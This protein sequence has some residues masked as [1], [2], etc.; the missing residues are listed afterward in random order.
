[1]LGFKFQGVVQVTPAHGVQVQLP[2]GYHLVAHFLDR[3]NTHGQVI[4]YSTGMVKAGYANG[5]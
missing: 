3:G 4:T 5:V 1:M 2:F